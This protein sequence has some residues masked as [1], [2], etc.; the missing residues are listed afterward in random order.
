MA[1]VESF[2]EVLRELGIRGLSETGDFYG[3]SLA[4]GTADVSLWELVNAYR[5]LAN[6]GIRG[7]LVL[8]VAPDRAERGQRVFS[9]E[10]AFIV[11]DILADREARSPTF[12]L[13]NPLATRFWTAVKTG[14]SKDM[15][16]NWCVGYSQRY[17]VGVWFGNFSGES[18]WDVSGMSGA[19]PV[20]LDLMNHLHRSEPSV[21]GRPPEATVLRAH[22]AGG[23]RREEWFIRGTDP[24]D[25]DPIPAGTPARIVYPPTGA[26]FVIDPDIPLERQ[27]MVFVASGA[28]GP[29]AWVL[30]GRRLSAG[31]HV[32][33]SP[34]PGAHALALQ[35]PGGQLLDT[36]FFQ[37]RGQSSDDS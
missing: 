4:L 30:D 1:G 20:W 29:P 13:E 14:T 25:G 12:G 24:T 3:P 5:A 32:D 33:W 35:D 37:V 36:V 2:L 21:V 11:S 28:E 15:R 17:S 7:E 31:S 22:S 23:G 26:V 19:A 6:G 8:A 18:M 10:A 16:D 27:R 34:T 9:P